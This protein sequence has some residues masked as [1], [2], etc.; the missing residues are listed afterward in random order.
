MLLVIGYPLAKRFTYWPQLMLGVTLNWGVLLGWLQQNGGFDKFSHAIP[1]Y[2]ACI[3]YTA[4]YDTIYAHQDK[5]DDRVIG[6]KSTALKFGDRSKT[7][8]AAIAGVILSNFLLTGWLCDQ[9]WPYYCG[10]AGFG[11]HLAWQVPTHL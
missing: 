9:T 3:C 8:L 5:A 11:A 4:F 10:V 7:L 6:V 1:L 2:L